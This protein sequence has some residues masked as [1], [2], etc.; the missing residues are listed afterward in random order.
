M[1]V[2]VFIVPVQDSGAASGELNAF[3]AAHRIL[4]VDRR[5]G[6]AGGRSRRMGSGKTFDSGRRDV[7][8]KPQN[9]GDGGGGLARRVVG[10]DAVG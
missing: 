8:F 9:L 3:L 1:A 6:A 2:K 7:C 4:C 10:G 5:W